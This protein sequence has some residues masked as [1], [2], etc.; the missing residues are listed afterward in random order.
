MSFEVF[1][2]GQGGTAEFV[3]KRH[4][5]RP[6]AEAHAA[7][8]NPKFWHSAGVRESDKPVSDSAKRGYQPVPAPTGPSPRPWDILWSG[9]GYCYVIDANGK[10]IG[11]LYGLQGLR[12]LNAAE[13]LRAFGPE[14]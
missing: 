5:T 7:G 2:T 14:A 9:A 1:A 13:I 3:L 6:E 11:T 10:K 8:L 4:E 12:E